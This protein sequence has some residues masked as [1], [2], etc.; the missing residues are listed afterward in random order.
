[1]QKLNSKINNTIMINPETP[2][3]LWR[4]LI[5]TLNYILNKVLNENTS[6]CVCE[7]GGGSC[8]SGDI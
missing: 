6:I 1:M 3:N 8:K 7:R 2:Q 5:L 4:E